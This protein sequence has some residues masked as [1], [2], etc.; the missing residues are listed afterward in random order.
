MP[1]V[2]NE[3]WPLLRNRSSAAFCSAWSFSGIIG[4]SGPRPRRRVGRTSARRA[5][6]TAELCGRWEGDSVCSARIP[7]RREARSLRSSAPT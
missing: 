5:G 2:T 6:S 3:I 7:P 4:G 1:R